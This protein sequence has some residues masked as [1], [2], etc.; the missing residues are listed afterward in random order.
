MCDQCP[1]SPRRRLSF[2]LIELLVVVAIIAVLAA[3]L[4]PAL[5]KARE[6]AK[7]T[8]C[9]GQLK[10]VGLATFMYADEHD[11]YLPPYYYKSNFW[12]G[13]IATYMGLGS[14]R[15]N[16]GFSPNVPVGQ[17]AILSCPTHV[18]GAGTYS[19]SYGYNKRIGYYHS[20]VYGYPYLELYKPRV[21]DRMSNPDKSYMVMDIADTN[22]YGSTFW[23]FEDTTNI[24]YRHGRLASAL[25]IDGRAGLYS[26]TEIRRTR[27][28]TRY[29]LGEK[30]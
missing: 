17:R 26:Y 13:R 28:S 11:G 30:D 15:F 21:L 24:D 9:L 3:M 29:W 23:T 4:L 10:Q 12:V 5:S 18:G 20:G 8:A 22:Q 14:T 7:A 2:T 25:T 6:R 19:I 1:P 27:Y 16:Y